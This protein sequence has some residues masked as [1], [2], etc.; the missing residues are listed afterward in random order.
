MPKFTYT[1]NET[2]DFVC[3]YCEKVVPRTNASTMHYHMKRHEGNLPFKCSTCDY[4]CLFQRS[5][6]LHRFAKHPQ[7]EGRPTL[8]RISCPSCPFQTLTKGNCIIHF[9][10]KHCRSEVQ[11]ILGENETCLRCGIEFHSNTAFQYHAS[12][13]IRIRDTARNELLQNLLTQAA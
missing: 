4:G 3:P 7:E 6:D 10:R 8:Q 1:R 11:E 12:S 9:L 5:L 2:G 13:C